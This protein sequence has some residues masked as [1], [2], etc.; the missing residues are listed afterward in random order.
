MKIVIGCKP[1]TWIGEVK[2]EE[3][4]E[5]EEEGILRFLPSEFVLILSD[6]VVVQYL[7]LSLIHIYVYKRQ[8]FV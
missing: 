2:E 6:E 7:G 4:E 8:L 3:E 1:I 5:E